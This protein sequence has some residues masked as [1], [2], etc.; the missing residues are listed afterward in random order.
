MRFGQ[1]AIS[2]EKCRVARDR[3]LEQ[4]RCLEKIFLQSRAETCVGTKCFGSHIQVVG[5]KIG[6]RCLL[7]GRFFLPG[8]LS[9]QLIGDSLGNF[10]L[11][12]EYVCEI[13]IV[14]L[15]PKM[16]VVAGID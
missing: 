12:G 13:A 10:A 6:R 16:R 2:K 3:L 5:D 11:N 1:S 8:E 7:D 9:V 14:S 4:M 15:C